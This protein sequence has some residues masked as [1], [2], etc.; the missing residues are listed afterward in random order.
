MIVGAH[1]RT[2]GGLASVVPGAQAIGADAAQFFASNAR[3]WR[4]PRIAEQTAEEFRRTALE[5]GLRSLLL[6]APYVVNIASPN[7]EFHRR[8]I[9]LCRESLAAADQLGARGLVVHAGAGGSGEPAD[10]LARAAAALEELA[11]TDSDAW[12]VVELMAGS[13]GAVASTIGEAVRLFDAVP[14][15]ERLRL[16]LDTCHLFAAGYRLDEPDGVAA[17]FDELSASGLADRLVA[18]HA[19]DAAF[20]AGSRRDR[21][22]NIGTGEIG[23]G[24]FAAILARPEVTACTVLCETPGDD[25]TRRR[26]VATL[27]EL[28]GAR[29]TKIEPP[30]ARPA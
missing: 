5:G 29:A 23:V 9:E 11:G 24:G 7:P 22:A 3:Q 18:L 4:P 6:H 14:R 17:C 15:N 20:P 25:A 12:P 16:C 10:G 8:S 26:D 19:N 27:R 30:P 21:H 1:I 2:H 28:A 13:M